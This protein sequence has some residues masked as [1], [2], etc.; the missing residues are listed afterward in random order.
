M[1]SKYTD[2]LLLP[3][4]EKANTRDLNDLKAN[5]GNITLGL[6]TTTEARDEDLIVLI[7]KVQATII[8]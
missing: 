7:D 4:G 1:I 2:L 3:Q 5:S 6:A 8:L